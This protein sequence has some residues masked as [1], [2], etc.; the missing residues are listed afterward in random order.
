ML[1]LQGYTFNA[2]LHNLNSNILFYWGL[3]FSF[4]ALQLK[5]KFLIVLRSRC[6][7][8]AAKDSAV[9]LITVL[10][11]QVWFSKLPALRVTQQLWH[12]PLQSQSYE[13]GCT[14]LNW[15]HKNQKHPPLLAEDMQEQA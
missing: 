15:L 3:E 12:A 7:V 9:V 6:A 13:A 10:G 1:H 2:H 5:Y 8:N 14:T 11:S 4:Q